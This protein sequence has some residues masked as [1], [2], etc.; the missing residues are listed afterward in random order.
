MFIAE[1]HTIESGRCAS[2]SISS[3]ETCQESRQKSRDSR[4]AFML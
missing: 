4:V 2:R 1:L 3:M